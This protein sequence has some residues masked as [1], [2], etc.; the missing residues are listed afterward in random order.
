[1][2]KHDISSFK[3]IKLLV[4]KHASTVDLQLLIYDIM[5]RNKEDTSMR[6]TAA[7]SMA[8]IGNVNSHNYDTVVAMVK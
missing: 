7:F 6:T 5:T 2:G 3:E 1:M 4:N 8:S